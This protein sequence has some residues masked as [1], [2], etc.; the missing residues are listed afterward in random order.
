MTADQPAQPEDG[1]DGIPVSGP[2]A[3][4]PR[5]EGPLP[6]LAGLF[7]AQFARE[8]AVDD[9]GAPSGAM[10]DVLL[11]PA[12]VTGALGA[13]LD[14]VTVAIPRLRAWGPLR[15]VEALE[16]GF[17]VTLGDERVE[18]P[19]TERLHV[20]E[21]AYREAG[22]APVVQYSAED[23][24]RLRSTSDAETLLH[25]ERDDPAPDAGEHPSA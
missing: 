9:G 1:T 13:E 16:D 10:P 11:D 22:G 5:Q 4:A 21:R 3:G 15:E 2:A 19:A 14:R 20:T 24:D 6:L 12:H 18:I 25:E 23:I 17:A 7:A 8:R